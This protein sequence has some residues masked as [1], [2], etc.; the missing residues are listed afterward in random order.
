MAI[1]QTYGD[2]AHR[3]SER[4]LVHVEK[5]CGHKT[6]KHHCGSLAPSEK[7]PRKTFGLL[8]TWGSSYDLRPGVAEDDLWRVVSCFP[9]QGDRQI[10]PFLS[11]H[12]DAY[13]LVL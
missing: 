5:M 6:R 10:C 11:A 12:A 9:E 2:K 13:V 8:S 3:D 1:S 4:C 7:E